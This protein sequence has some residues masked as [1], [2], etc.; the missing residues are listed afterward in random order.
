M[1]HCLNCRNADVYPS[2]GSF[3]VFCQKRVRWVY[4]IEVDCKDFVRNTVVMALMEIFEEGT[5]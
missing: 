3:A 2:G 5:K 4:V 1:N